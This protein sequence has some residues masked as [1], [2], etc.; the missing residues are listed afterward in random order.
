M[1]M[2]FNL[3]GKVRTYEGLVEGMLKKIFKSKRQKTTGCS[4]KLHNEEV[5]NL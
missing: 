1:G 4:N 3:E 2:K 5:H